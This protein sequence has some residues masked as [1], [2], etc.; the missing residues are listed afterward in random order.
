MNHDVERRSAWKQ[1]QSAQLAKPSFQ[2]IPVDRGSAVLRNDEADA[3][4][5]ETRKG[6]DSPNVEMFGS[7]SLPCSCDAAQLRAAR[8]AAAALERL[9]LTRRRTCSGAA[10]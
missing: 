4:M 10:R 6:S 7:E 3:G 5:V 1:Q 9:G 2:P 8:D